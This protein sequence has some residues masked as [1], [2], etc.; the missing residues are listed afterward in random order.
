L[1][2]TLKSNLSVEVN[3][4]VQI[5]FVGFQA[6]VDELGGIE[7]SFAYPARDAKSG[8]DIPAGEQSLD[9]FEALAYARSRSY[10]ELQNGSWVGV[11]AND[12]GRTQRQQEVMRAI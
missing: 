10:Q 12:I 9:G 2:E 6:L 7:M 3:H 11:D 8:L 4:Y 1:V 5:D